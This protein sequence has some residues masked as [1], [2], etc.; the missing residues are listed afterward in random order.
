M[1]VSTLLVS[2]EQVRLPETLEHFGVDSKG[3]GLEVIWQL[4]PGI[5]PALTQEDVDPVVL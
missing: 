2:E 3:V 5:V 1:K 4:Q